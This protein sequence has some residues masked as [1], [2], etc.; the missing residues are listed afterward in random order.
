MTQV[1]NNEG[2]IKFLREGKFHVDDP[3]TGRVYRPIERTCVKPPVL[4]IPKSM[5]KNAKLLVD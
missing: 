5:K 3:I 4:N 2:Q 1:H